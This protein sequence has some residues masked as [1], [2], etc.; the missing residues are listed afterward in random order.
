MNALQPAVADFLLYVAAGKIQPWAIKPDTLLVLVGHPNHHRGYIH[1]LAEARVK[2]V[3]KIS[4]HSVTSLEIANFERPSPISA[5]R[6]CRCH[7]HVTPA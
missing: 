5:T 7:E 3:R 6:A 4:W 1:D 2:F